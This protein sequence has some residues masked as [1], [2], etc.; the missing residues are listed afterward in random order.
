MDMRKRRE[1][2]REFANYPGPEV[3]RGRGKRQNVIEELMIKPLHHRSHRLRYLCKIHYETACIQRPAT[4]HLHHIGVSV[5]IATL[6]P[7]REIRERM[8][9]LEREL[10]GNRELH[11]ACLGLEMPPG[12]PAHAMPSPTNHVVF[13]H[14]TNESRLRQEARTRVSP[15]AGGLFGAGRPTEQK[16]APHSEIHR[17]TT[18]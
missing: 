5:N 4:E 17:K 14:Y 18:A 12:K 7:D 8:R 10:F 13:M 2:R 16:K 11:F 1:R 3:L 15:H 9:R 6:V